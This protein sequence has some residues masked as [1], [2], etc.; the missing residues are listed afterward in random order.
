MQ[1][2]EFALKSVAADAEGRFS[3]WA[4]TYHN[5]DHS[6]DVVMPG[7]FTNTIRENNGV[8]RILAQHDRGDVIGL[9][10]L[11]D[12]PAEGLW[13]DGQLELALASARDAYVRLRGGLIDSLSIGYV[14]RKERFDAKRGVR[15]LLDIDLLEVSLVTFPAN[16]HARVVSV[17]RDTNGELT[18]MLTALRNLRQSTEAEMA[19]DALKHFNERL[20]RSELLA[21]CGRYFTL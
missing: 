14:T 13:I 15:E 16:A 7:A 17:K 4:S 21:G 19:S 3:G 12:R 10:R 2:R 5:E 9:A 6:G 20:T 8:I 18:S 1:K 11:T